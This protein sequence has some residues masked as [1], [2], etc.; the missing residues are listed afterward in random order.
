M[1][2]LQFTSDLKAKLKGEHSTPENALV[3]TRERKY[4]PAL[5]IQK[6]YSEVND[7]TVDRGIS[8]IRGRVNGK[9]F[10]SFFL[11]FFSRRREEMKLKENMDLC[12]INGSWVCRPPQSGRFDSPP[13]IQPSFHP[14][15]LI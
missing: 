15:I 5:K 12:E 1:V 3:E 14:S 11:S 9:L 6:P 7:Q 2:H 8:A 4:T 10:L 13:S